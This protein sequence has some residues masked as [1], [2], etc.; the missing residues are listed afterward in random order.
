MQ[1]SDADR[2]TLNRF[3]AMR[4]PLATVVAVVIILLGVALIAVSAMGVETLL[5]LARQTDEIIALDPS[6]V[7]DSR[8]VETAVQ[9]SLNLSLSVAGVVVGVGMVIMSLS[10]LV[11]SYSRRSLEVLVRRLLADS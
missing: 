7:A 3:L 5:A 9:I 2:E 4:G 6:R 11:R 10:L 8:P 1:I